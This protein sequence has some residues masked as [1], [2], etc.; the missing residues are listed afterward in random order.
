MN[1]TAGMGVLVSRVVLGIVFFIH[2]LMKYQ[3]GIE[4]TMGF[5]DS[6]G[7]P[8]YMAYP[9][10]GLEIIGGVCMVLGLGTRIFAAIFS[11]IMITAIGFA[12]LAMGFAGYELEL[13]LL[14]M[15]LHLLLAGSHF[16]ALDRVFSNQAPPST[17]SQ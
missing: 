10:G 8:G 15:S 12:K 16:W 13:I 6:L 1:S 14:A 3:G 17:T 5:F 11:I 2:G 7:I 9:V 4:N